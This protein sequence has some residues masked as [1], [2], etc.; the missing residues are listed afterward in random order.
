[1]N[2]NLWNSV[3]LYLVLYIFGIYLDIKNLYIYLFLFD[4]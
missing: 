1:M 4:L 3:F 2:D